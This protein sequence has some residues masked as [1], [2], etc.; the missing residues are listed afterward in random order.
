MVPFQALCLFIV[1]CTCH[2]I[3]VIEISA[4]QFSALSDLSF[5]KIELRFVKSDMSFKSGTEFLKQE[6]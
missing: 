5:P 3:H 6:D 1:S 4:T 2:N